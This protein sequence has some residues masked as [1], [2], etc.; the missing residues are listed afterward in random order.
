M[1]KTNLSIG[2]M[3]ATA[4]AVMALF[5][6]PHPE[7]PRV[8]VTTVRPGSLQKVA[9]LQG[10]SIQ[11]EQIPVVAPLAG[12][13][14]QV[15]VKS[16]ERVQA[17]QLLVR[18]DAQMEEQALALLDQQIYQL[19]Y[20][21]S[22]LMEPQ[23]SA[24]LTLLTS[25]A[26]QRTALVTAIQCKQIRA[27]SEGISENLYVK[28][29][30]YLNEAG[31]IGN[32]CGS[33]RKVIAYWPLLQGQPPFPGMMA[34]WCTQEGIREEPLILESVG[35]PVEQ[36]QTLT[37][38]LV[39]RSM[40]GEHTKILQGEGAPVCLILQEEQVEAMVPMEALD[41]NQQLWVV[42]NGQ[43]APVP[44]MVRQHNDEFVQVADELAG[45]QVVLQPDELLLEDGMVMRV[46]EGM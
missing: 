7:A 44:A 36:K 9:M 16:G 43:T 21:F 29:G 37:Y 6:F 42:R 4:V 26:E 30:D 22:Q 14:A 11:G 35:A 28:A 32:L 41:S 10:Q 19:G 39:F 31:L 34:W 46:A 8:A 15:Y 40:L 12:K 33:E 38:P 1:S 25:L 13:V 3:I 2:V 24:N 45:E 5:F 23:D 18:L 17:G 27:S 20:R